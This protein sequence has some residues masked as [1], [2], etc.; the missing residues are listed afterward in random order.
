MRIKDI[1]LSWFRGAADSVSMGPNC[2]SIV[3]YGENASG[4]SSFVDAIE[5]VL[6]G[7]RVGHL[8]HEYSGKNLKKA[9]PNTHKPKGSKAEFSINLCDN[10]VVKIE[11]KDDGSANVSG[12]MAAALQGWD[13]RRT[14]LRQDEVVSF[15][16]NTKGEKYSALLPL[17]G[18]QP[19]EI[20]AENLRQLTRN[21]DSLS[22]IDRSKA[23]L[24]QTKVK[25]QSTFGTSTD[26]EILK[27]IGTLHGKYC[28]DRDTAKHGLSLCADLAASLQ[29]RISAFSADQKRYSVLRAVADLD[30]KSHVDSI[31]AANAALAGAIDPLIAQK[32]AVL[33]PSEALAGK[34]VEDGELECPACGQLIQISEF[35]EHVRTELERLREIRETFNARSV[36]MGNLCDAIKSLKINTGKAEVK[37]WRDE[38]EK[39]AL[40]KSLWYLEGLNAE[41]LRT[42]CDEKDL[43]QIEIKL[44]A[45]IDAANSASLDAPPDVKQLLDDKNIVDAAQA[46]FQANDEAARVVSAE[47]LISLISALEEI[48]R[49]QIRQRSNAVIAEISD[50]IKQMWSILHP[51]E[52][53][54]DVHLYLPDDADKAID[55]SLK[56]HGKELD[57]PRL[58]LSEGYRNSLGL[59]IFMAMAKREGATDRPVILDDVVVSL[60]RNHRGMIVDLLMKEFSKRQVI[61]LTHDRDWYT[62]LRQLLDEGAWTFKALLPYET[63]QIGIRWSHKTTTFDD[64]RAHL[65]GR[66]DS[67]VNDARKIMDVELA[68]IAERLQIRLPYLRLDKND[69]RTAHEFLERLLADGKKCLQRGTGNSSAIH[70]V[71]IEALKDADELLVSWGNRGSHTFDI[72]RPE[73]A[74]LIDACEKAL[75]SLKCPSCNKA[76]WFADAAGTEWVQCQCGEIR[77]RY[78]KG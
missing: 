41:G 40:A 2:K 24:N 10:S 63:P 55:I 49:E 18:L 16:Q 74:K 42:V 43:H 72:V 67:A 45:L 32:I 31:R 64:A 4:K 60:D 54:E 26:E 75:E 36:A 3:V 14:V 12:S 22:Q 8:A 11:I 46:A 78:G 15:I 38:L 5:Y 52:A 73:A 47:A 66:P 35:R 68:L 28:A 1:T 23:I 77:W 37:P 50:D 27:K 34:L 71:A 6:N 33:Q 39:G 9:L 48:T 59:C 7:G 25:R 53:I 29:M 61:I 69:R 70:L 20:A 57:S 30:L 76:V 58:T 19:M 44:L 56:F 65:K 62:E 13:Y 17:F 51:G 21:I